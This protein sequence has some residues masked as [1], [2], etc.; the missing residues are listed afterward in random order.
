MSSE[1]NFRVNLQGMVDLL[2]HHLYSGPGVYLRELVQNSVDAITA[3]RLDDPDHP[4]HITITPADASADGRLWITDD[5]IGLDAEDI[6]AVLST[7][8]ATSKRDE[9]GFQREGFLGQ[10]GIGLLSCFMVSD[11]IDVRTRTADGPTWQ[12]RGRSDGTYDVRPAEEDLPAQ[13][14]EVT[15]EPGHHPDLL[16]TDAVRALLTRYAAFLPVDIELVTA[17]GTES[18]RREFPWEVRHASP[19]DRRSATIALCEDLLGFSPMD[20]IELAD[21]ESGVRG[22]AFVSPYP[23][24]HR[25]AH[26]VYARHMLVNE[27]ADSVLPDWAFFL[28]A[29]IDTEQLRPT[30]SREQLHEDDLLEET[31]ARLGQ[32]VKKWLIRMSD[33]DP[34]RAERFMAVHSLGVKA[35]ASQD[36]EMLEFVG[37][38]L[39]FETTQ[40]SLTLAELTSADRLI[41]YCDRV[42]E[43]RQLAPIA[44]AQ[45][46]TLVNAGYAYD[47]QLI[48]KWLDHHPGVDARRMTSA[49]LLAALDPVGEPERT[50]F[51]SL[52]EVAEACLRSTRF[53]PLLRSFEPAEATAV[54]LSGRDA[55]R[56]ADRAAVSEV[57]EGAWLAALDAIADDEAADGGTERPRAGPERREPDRPATGRHAGRCRA[58]AEHRSDLR[59]PPAVG[60]TPGQTGRPGDRLAGPWR[61]DRSRARN[62]RMQTGAHAPGPA[63]SSTPSAARLRRRG[64][65]WSATGRSSRERPGRGAFRGLLRRRGTGPDAPRRGAPPRARPARHADPPGVVAPGGRPSGARPR[66]KRSACACTGC[67]SG[68]PT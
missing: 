30:A 28:R 34:V 32:Q 61:A 13:G 11:R 59:P 33:S 64:A 35:M 41:T 14:T 22:V 15:L 3:R 40:G 56:E 47:S 21:P 25:G 36:D 27:S 63:R 43:Y 65:E 39:G 54:L 49:E 8:G 68:L 20:Q 2:G 50:R 17:T 26:R 45:R 53:A 1:Q 18:P 7:I 46:M 62:L 10:F 5:G 31:R 60:A 42:D 58:A 48:A 23:G 19:A 66:T 44:Q 55:D 12:W 16:H 37:S 6:R 67:S 9:L 52:L 51:D 57:A 24:M 38:I 29:V 4:G